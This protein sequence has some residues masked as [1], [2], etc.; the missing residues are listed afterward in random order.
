MLSFDL[1]DTISNLIV[2]SNP[3]IVIFLLTLPI[4]ITVLGIARYIIGVKSLGIYAPIVL[5]FLFFQFGT[6]GKDQVDIL[7]GFK[8]GLFLTLII[9]VSCF[10]FYKLIQKSSLHY[11]SKLSMVVTGISMVLLSILVLL[12]TINREGLLRINIFSLVLIATISELYL[13]LFAFKGTREAFIRSAETIILASVCFI[14]I[15]LKPLQ[16]FLIAY[17]WVIILNF[18]INYFVGRFAGLR[19]TEYYRFRDIL[20]HEQDE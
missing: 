3:N 17:P 5:S 4:V 1:T 8:Y 14:I 2:S 10:L 11:Y 15:S 18:P 7:Q 6:I 13:N 19:L 20:N 9:F 16:D 12:D